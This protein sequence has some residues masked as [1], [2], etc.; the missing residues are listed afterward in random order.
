MLVQIQR[1][2][3]CIKMIEVESVR[4]WQE[5]VLMELVGKSK[6]KSIVD[7]KY[8]QVPG[9]ENISLLL[10]KPEVVE[11][12]A[13]SAYK[14]I[15]SSPIP[16]PAKETTIGGS[17]CIYTGDLECLK[18]GVLPSTKER[19]GSLEDISN[20]LYEYYPRMD[21]IHDAFGITS[22]NRFLYIVEDCLFADRISKWLEKPSWKH[23]LTELIKT[24][25]Q[26]VTQGALCRWVNLVSHRKPQIDFI[27][28]SD[29]EEDLWKLVNDFGS[30]LGVKD[31][32]NRFDLAPVQV[33]YTHLWLNFLQKEGY[34]KEPAIFCSEP[35]FHFD[36]SNTERYYSGSYFRDNPYGKIGKCHSFGASGT[37][38]AWYHRKKTRGLP[39]TQ[40]VNKQLKTEQIRNNNVLPLDQNRIVWDSINY[41]FWD[42]HA[43]GTLYDILSM[44]G[45]HKSKNQEDQRSTRNEL[46]EKISPLLDILDDKLVDVFSYIYGK[47]RYVGVSPM[48]P[49]SRELLLQRFS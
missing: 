16:A 30:E 45:H 41:L 20:W 37:F 3:N 18:N 11:F 6:W 10:D 25:H 7:K 46:R 4:K 5:N 23:G 29:V 34:V 27:Y 13:Q 14:T 39:C 35:Y 21:Q 47:N 44:Y 38:P 32:R 2:L 31:L 9:A 17:C 12:L 42:N 26:E 22:S 40:V 24:H 48:H 43:R 36:L 33:V 49:A 1:N 28:L 8:A 15:F 19:V